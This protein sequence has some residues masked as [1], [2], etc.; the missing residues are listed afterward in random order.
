MKIIYIHQ[1]F[2]TPE[3]G[4]A[5][6]SYHMAKKLVSEGYEVEMITSHN[7]QRYRKASIDGISVHYLPVFYQNHFG[8]VKRVYAFIKFVFL[9]YRLIKGIGKVD[10]IYAT[11]TPLTVGWL[12]LKIKKNLG[13][14]YLFEVRDLW[15]DAPIEMGIIK[16]RFL[17]NKLFEMEKKIY[18]HS[19]GVIV[20]SPPVKSIIE[21]RTNQSV[22]LIPNVADIDFF[23][24][25]AKDNGL[26]KSL[27]IEN[28]FVVVYAGAI[29]KVNRL[30]NMIRLANSCAKSNLPIKF[31]IIGEGASLDHMK[32]ETEKLGLS[33]IRFIPQQNKYDL[34]QYLYLADAAYISFDYPE[35]LETSSPNKLFDALAGG[36]LIIYNKKGWIKEL[37]ETNGCGFYH[38]PE[39][40]DLSCE[41]LSML[42]NDP[43]KLKIFQHNSLNTA[44]LFS[45]EEL[46]KKF[47]HTVNSVIEKSIN[48]EIRSLK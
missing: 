37:I 34:R 44:R 4:G 18:N 19:E 8:F 29:G 38:D 36:K 43:E 30:E 32:F 41:M 48:D 10:L 31:L 46:L 12:A 11:S 25:N 1:Y 2:K 3:E 16:Q 5:I 24:H 23:N 33:N 14:P 21:S 28:D 42:I 47:I 13:I 15:P 22:F 27:K 7:Y 40:Q 9:A 17:K 39:N 45:K 20:L 35:I 26:A 6:R